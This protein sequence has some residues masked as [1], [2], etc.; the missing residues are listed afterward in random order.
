MRNVK[1]GL[2][3][4]IFVAS[5]TLLCMQTLAAA[6]SVGW[7]NEPAGSTVITDYSFDTIPGQGWQNNGG[8]SIV[9]DPTAPLSPSSVL[10]FPYP[11][12]FIGGSA[13]D[14]AFYPLNNLSEIYLG[15]WWKP[16]NP[17]Q[18][19]PSLFNKIA[20]Q[21][22][23]G[24]GGQLFQ[25]MHGNGVDE[26]YQVIST[27]EFTVDNSHLNQFGF[28]QPNGAWTLFGNASKGKVSLGQWHRIEVYIKQGTTKSSK[29]GILRWWVDGIL[30]GNYSNVNYPNTLFNEFQFSPTWGG[31]GETKLEGDYYYFDHVHISQPSG[32]A[33]VTPPAAPTNLKVN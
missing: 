22:T 20:F 13:P 8:S 30:V 9:I 3:S 4:T 6:Q 19:H 26:P 29:N 17:W 11:V 15:Y 21:F 14:T 31:V 5:V 1:P 18:A 25:V 32:G 10:K 33:D 16:S 28:G 12:G 2:C 24:S 23:N 27:L 7:P